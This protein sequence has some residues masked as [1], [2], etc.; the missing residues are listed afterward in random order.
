MNRR[1]LILAVGLFATLFLVWRASLQ[2]GTEVE[3]VEPVRHRPAAVGKSAPAAPASEAGKPAVAA[4]AF[5][6][7]NL[8]PVQSWRPPP[9]PPPP[10]TP[11][12]PPPEP[13]APPLPFKLL[14][15]WQ[16]GGVTTYFLADGSQEYSLSKGQSAGPWRLDEAA[17]GR[18]TF[19]YT[20]LN[21]TQ[22]MRFAQ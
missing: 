9:P 16:E 21:K 6:T 20:P 19:T 14:G 22:T 12:G 18:L 11:P 3:M 2:E 10:P 5:D 17:P 15:S 1:Q 8:F 4:R 7:G 13:V